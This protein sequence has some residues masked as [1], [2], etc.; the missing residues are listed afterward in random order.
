MQESATIQ[1][2]ARHILRLVAAKGGLI[3]IETPL[4]SMSWFDSA[5]VP[6]FVARPLIWLWP[7]L[8]CLA[9]SREFCGTPS[10]RWHL[11]QPSYGMLFDKAG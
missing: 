7:Q 8:A 5:L 1:D 2:R 4:M 9:K 11:L 10:T 3:V 6:G